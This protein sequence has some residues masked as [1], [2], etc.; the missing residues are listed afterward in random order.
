MVRLSRVLLGVYADYKRER[1]LIDMNDLE[2]GALALLRDSTLSGWVQERLDAR[3]H[4][5]L[6]DEFQDT[7]PLQWHALHA[8]LAAYAGA[9]GGVSGQRAPALFVVGDPKQSIY[10]FRRAE[11]KVFGAVREFVV[12]AL[13][14]CVLECD[15][16]R[17]NTPE[18][19]AGLNAV[20]AAAQQ[21]GEFEGFRAHTTEVDP[22]QSPGLWR[23]PPVPRPPAAPRSGPAEPAPWRDS[24]TEP[25]HEPEELL[26]EEE[27]RRVAD[28]V[29]QELARGTAP[30]QVM[31]LCRKRAPLRLVARALQQRHVPHVAV[32]DAAL[33]ESTEALDLL[34]LLDALVSPQH[35]L[36]L[37]RALRSP[38]FDASDADLLDLSQ[39]AVA[40]GDWWPALTGYDGASVALQRACALLPAWQAASRDLPPHDLLDRIVAQG[41]LRERLA[42][43]VPA[44]QR[45]V[46][47]ASVDAVLAQALE[48]D[49]G[50]YATPYAFVRALRRRAITIV[51]PDLGDAVKLLTVHGA[52]GLEAEVVFVMDADPEP[53]RSDNA[54]LLVDWPVQASHPRRCAFLYSESRCPPELAG[55][56]ADEQQARRREELNGLY[57]AMT[58]AR[59]RLVF[60]ATEPLRRSAVQANW[61]PRIV[62]LA[63]PWPSAAGEGGT[64]RQEPG[65]ALEVL[66]RWSGI[67][68]A[69]APAPAADSAASRLGSAVHRVLEWHT[70]SGGDL[71]PLAVAAAETFGVPA[72]EVA[73]VAGR[74]LASADCARFFDA[75]SLSWAGNEVPISLAG[76]VLRI[77]RLVLLDEAD[78]PTWWVLDYKL[79]HRPQELA[80]YHAQLAGYRGAVQAAQPGA[81][82]R[83]AFIAGDGS[84]IESV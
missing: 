72:D 64:A 11:P 48:L 55:P 15:H 32:D 75:R 68:A 37:A 41:E 46:A 61:W 42:A 36:S 43:R 77:D 19:L 83:S 27:A 20:F 33:I 53:P 54:T 2:H 28:A 71:A 8:W 52:K 14:G 58:R 35:R 47:L 3:I 31:V 73:R 76:A 63:P 67:A 23:L 50:R 82:V 66:P 6:I 21:A 80:E 30:E 60:S 74:I 34:A 12:E 18:L 84:L 26:R 40:A 44:A 79:Q 16:T 45:A 49:G 51:A 39:R 69:T 4:H 29:V 25:R 17:R 81:R 10:R 5:V 56:L 70:G 7:S 22:A 59:R 65:P 78:G 1:G 9:G 13:G 62:G 24:L 57:V 38:L